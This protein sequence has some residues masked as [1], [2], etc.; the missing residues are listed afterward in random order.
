MVC[1]IR[2]TVAGQLC[3]QLCVPFSRRSQ[4]LTLAHEV[5]G[6]H[7]GPRKTRDRIRLTFYWP[8]L[9]SNCKQHCRTCEQCQKRART[10]V[11][12]RVPISPIPRADKVF[13]HWFMDCLGP[14]FLN[15]NVRYNH[16][17]V[18]CDSTSRW[19][20]AYPLHSLS[21]KSVSD[22][23]FD[24]VFV[25]R[26]ARCHLVGQR[27][28]FQKESNHRIFKTAWMLPQIFNSSS[29]TSLRFDGTYGRLDQI[30]HIQSCY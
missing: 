5:Y 2:A 6:A 7:L 1:C 30:C 14:L 15:Q 17:L 24:P 26:G 18:L 29:S 11:R 8:N 20:A 22:A 25:N 27:D 4:V 19:P 9:T 16:C 3:E 28:K 21:A 13:S 23:R 10:T 12:D